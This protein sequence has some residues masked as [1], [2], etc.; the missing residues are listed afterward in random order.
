MSR[1]LPGKSLFRPS[2][3]QCEADQGNPG[4]Q[5]AGRPALPIALYAEDFSVLTRIRRVRIGRTGIIL[6][7]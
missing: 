1:Q 2:T 3:G 6:L 4:W 5:A 7:S